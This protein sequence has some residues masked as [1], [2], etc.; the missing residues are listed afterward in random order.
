ME[1]L[2]CFADLD[3]ASPPGL[4]AVSA[5]NG[6]A[7]LGSFSMYGRV[8][9]FD[10]RQPAHPRLVSAAFY[11]NAID[12]SVFAFAFSG[13]D[14]FV[15]GDMFY[16]EIFEADITQPR[17]FMRHMCFP[18]PFGANAGANFPELQKRL[19]GLSMWN[20]K[21]HLKKDGNTR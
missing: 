8:F 13:S 15:A 11:G 18:P 16:D 10:Y 20:P 17:N 3:P 19:S 5:N 9:G 7:Y 14:M 2:T 12:E 6:I 21:T 1:P 4:V